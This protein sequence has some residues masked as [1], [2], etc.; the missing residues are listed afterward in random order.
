MPFEASK[1]HVMP[2]YAYHQ[3]LL[4]QKNAGRFHPAFESFQN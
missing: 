2:L 3:W 1:K 4:K